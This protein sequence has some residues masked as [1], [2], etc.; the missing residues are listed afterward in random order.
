MN[1]GPEYTCII[2]PRTI[3][4]PNPS[5]SNTFVPGINAKSIEVTELNII[6]RAK[7]AATA[8]DAIFPLTSPPF[9]DTLQILLA[10]SEHAH[11]CNPDFG[12]N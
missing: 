5:R 10:A 12:A 2:G 6:T 3:D 9:T 8:K 11:F 7:T 1:L 4:Q